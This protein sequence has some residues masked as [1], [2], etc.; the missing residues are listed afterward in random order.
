[1]ANHCEE[2]KCRDGV[3]QWILVEDCLSTLLV[4]GENGKTVSFS[5]TG[6]NP[7]QQT[8]DF[9]IRFAFSNHCFFLKLLISFFFINRIAV[10]VTVIK[11]GSIATHLTPFQ[12]K[13]NPQK[14]L[15]CWSYLP[16]MLLSFTGSAWQLWVYT[17]ASP[18][19]Y[20]PSTFLLVAIEKK[21]A[22]SQFGPLG[23][24]IL[25]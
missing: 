11:T 1:M 7:T 22:R 16:E 24:V 21:F 4:I 12:L 10:I 13:L 15:Y 25:A 3:C 20:P 6:M 23:A 14:Q 19:L 2:F 5:T 8:G 17:L 9:F 18:P